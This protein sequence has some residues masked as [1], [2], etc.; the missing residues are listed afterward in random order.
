M[1]SPVVLVMSNIYIDIVQKNNTQSAVVHK[2]H[3]YHHRLCVS[4][5]IMLLLADTRRLFFFS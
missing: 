5:I 3:D 2:I 1:N 4:F